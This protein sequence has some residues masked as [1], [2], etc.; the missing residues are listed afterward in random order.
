MK[1]RSDWTKT[2]KKSEKQPPDSGTLSENVNRNKN[3]EIEN[4][5]RYN[6]MSVNA[7]DYTV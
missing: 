4:R 6:I 2:A 5:F 1:R 3:I 7:A